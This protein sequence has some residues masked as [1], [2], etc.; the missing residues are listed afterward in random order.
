MTLQALAAEIR[1]AMQAASDV[2]LRIAALVLEAKEKHFAGNCLGW[3][4]W[5]KEEFEF[6]RRHAFRIARVGDFVRR[7]RA[8]GLFKQLVPHVALDVA[9]LEELAAI[10]VDLFEAF[11]AAHDVA[12]LDRDELRSAVRKYLGIPDA[13][14]RQQDFFGVLGLPTPER[15]K[16]DLHRAVQRHQVPPRAAL[17]YGTLLLVAAVEQAEAMTSDDLQTLETVLDH[18]RARA[19][20][21]GR[22]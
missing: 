22:H 17:E 2:T 11:L 13:A 8:A 4:A 10:P 14:P 15:F 18:L 1:K 6:S 20:N 12:E 3:L 5:C 7:V 19:A 9:K 21:R 16:A